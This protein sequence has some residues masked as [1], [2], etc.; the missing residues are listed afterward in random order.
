MIHC[1]AKIQINYRR[2]IGD[3]A[4]S[5]LELPDM[6]FVLFSVALHQYRLFIGLIQFLFV[7]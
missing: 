2:G 5:L 4:D 7:V 6:V 1:P 3:F